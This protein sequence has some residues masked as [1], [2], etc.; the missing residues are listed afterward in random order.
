MDHHA[1]S[2]TPTLADHIADAIARNAHRA[3]GQ[4]D[5]A[6]DALLAPLLYRLAATEAGEVAFILTMLAAEK[7]G[8]LAQFQAVVETC[9]GWTRQRTGATDPEVRSAALEAWAGLVGAANALHTA[10]SY[11]DDAAATIRSALPDAPAPP[12]PSARVRLRPTVQ[13]V[14]QAARAPSPSV[15]GVDRAAP[16]T[17]ALPGRSPAASPPLSGGSGVPGAHEHR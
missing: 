17:P 5:D 2:R 11:L 16:D 4:E 9:A 6:P 12:A 1:E 8:E 3:R 14:L 13:A 10:R 7:L 15:V